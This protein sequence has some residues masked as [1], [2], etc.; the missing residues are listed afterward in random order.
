MTMIA[1]RHGPHAKGP[2]AFTLIELLTVVAIIGILAAILIPVVG[3]ARDSA[4][5]STC[6]SNLRQIGTALHLYHDDHGRFPDQNDT[7]YMTLAGK[8]GTGNEMEGAYRKDASARPLNPYLD[9]PSQREAEAEIVHCPSDDVMYHRA[10]SSYAYSNVNLFLHLPPRNG[11]LG[12]GVQLNHIETP[13]RVLAAY[14]VNAALIAQSQ[15]A[16]N[17]QYHGHATRYNVVFADGHVAFL[18]IEPG[19]RVTSAYSFFWDR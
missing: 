4:R 5:Q 13:G 18:K 16:A 2:S 10:G 19:R 17:L 12:I 14:E 8:A 9:V 7:S 1:P 15:G 3:K 11:E 6:A